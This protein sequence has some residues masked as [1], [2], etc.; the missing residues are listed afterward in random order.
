MRRCFLFLFF[1][2]FFIS[3][4]ILAS[5]QKLVCG[6]GTLP[7]L[8]SA[9]TLSLGVEQHSPFPYA[10]QYDIGLGNRVQLGISAYYHVFADVE[11]ISMFNVLKTPDDRDFFSLYF[12]PNLVYA[13]GEFIPEFSTGIALEHRFGDKRRFGVFVKNGV[14][15]GTDMSIG[16]PYHL[17]IEY[18][19]GFQGLLGRSFSI[20]LEQQIL[21]NLFPELEQIGFKVA[22][23]WIFD[24]KKD[25]T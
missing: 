7:H 5:D 21:L 20:A 18:N 8:T 16:A 2:F 4:R 22:F 1:T 24:M 17:D 13:V 25:E 6:A 19:S 11:I 14:F 12:N 23:S 10:L 9:I 3:G 15:I